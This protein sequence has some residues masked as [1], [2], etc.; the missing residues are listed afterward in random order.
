MQVHKANY[1][2]NFE[3]DLI[4]EIENDDERM[5]TPSAAKYHVSFEKLS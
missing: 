4:I 5:E 1:C 2:L 3:E